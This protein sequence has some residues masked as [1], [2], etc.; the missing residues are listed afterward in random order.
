MIGRMGLLFAAAAVALSSVSAMAATIDVTRFDDP[1]GPCDVSG[2]S[3]RQAVLLANSTPG[4]DTITLH[5]GKY[6][7]KLTGDGDIERVAA[8]RRHVPPWSVPMATPMSTS[9][10]LPMPKP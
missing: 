7:L 8:V 6:K 3:L 10:P 4:P 2:C 5:P 9:R 1:P